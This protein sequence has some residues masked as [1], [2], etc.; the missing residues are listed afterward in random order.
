[1]PID[2]YHIIFKSIISARRLLKDLKLALGNEVVLLEVLQPC[3]ENVLNQQCDGI[4]RTRRQCSS[5]KKMHM[6]RLDRCF[7]HD[8][9]ALITLFSQITWPMRCG[10]RHQQ[11]CLW[12]SLAWLVHLTQRKLDT[13][14]TSEPYLVRFAPDQLSHL[15]FF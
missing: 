14:L 6:V 10:P 4:Y 15:H 13:V 11:L 5:R 1:M 9:R 3:F 2:F 8:S 12:T 7:L